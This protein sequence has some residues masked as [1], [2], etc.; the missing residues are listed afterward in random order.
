MNKIFL[1]LLSLAALSGVAENLRAEISIDQL[2][3][4][5][6]INEGDIAV[7]DL[8][9]WNAARKILVNDDG[10]DL[11]Q[12]SAAHPG[13]EF[14]EVQS[15]AEAM[16]H[17]SDVDA[18]VGF[19]NPEMIAAARNLVWVQVYWAGVERCLP[20]EGIASGAVILTNMQKMSAPVIA[21]HAIAMMLSLARNLPGFTREM[22]AAKWS[23]DD[24]ATRGMTPIAGKNLLVVGLGGI[25]TEVARL[26]NALGMKVSGTRNSSRSGPDFIEYVG[27]SHE[28]NSM[29]AKADVVVNALPLT[30]ATSGTFD[31]EFFATIK[32]G[33]IFINVGRGRTVVTEDLL[34]ALESGRVSAAGLDVTD[35]EPLPASHS[36][37]QRDDVIITP[38]VAGFGGER[39]RHGVLLIENLRR[40][41]AGD[42]LLNVVDPKKGY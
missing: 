41:I 3:Q 27:L 26:G 8:P 16:R 11:S 21:E 33:A 42:A 6:R 17:T 36:L 19:C 13:V 37:W 40:Y 22:I 12:L 14:I 38:H 18:I 32:E 35:P 4:Q 1:L 7:R 9:R 2:V 34:D 10:Y 24:T 28:L 23:R 29:A 31:D 20:V 15:V 39:E 5:A 30:D 25:G